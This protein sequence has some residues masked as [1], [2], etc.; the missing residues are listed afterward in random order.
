[1]LLEDDPHPVHPFRV[2]EPRID[3]PEDP[4][5]DEL[6]GIADHLVLVREVMRDHP[7]RKTALARNGPD[8]G[9]ADTV[10]GDHLDNRPDDI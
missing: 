7:A 1:M 9:S 5:G 3:S 2:L 8:G 6:E 4:V 10:F